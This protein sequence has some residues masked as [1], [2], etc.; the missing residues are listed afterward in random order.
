M[1]GDNKALLT[2]QSIKEETETIGSM[3]EMSVE[4]EQYVVA[5]EK[6][7]Q[8]EIN[9]EDIVNTITNKL[10]NLV[11]FSVANLTRLDIRS[12]VYTFRHKEASIAA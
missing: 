8:T 1:I 2:V 11:K 10:S 9:T 4:L 7:T 5:M 3:T 12:T 6:T